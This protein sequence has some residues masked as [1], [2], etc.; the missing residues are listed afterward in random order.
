MNYMGGRPPNVGLGESETF[1]NPLLVNGKH[2][3]T[4]QGG[5]ERSE[6]LDVIVV[7]HHV[8][9]QD[10]LDHAQGFSGDTTNAFVATVMV[11]AAVNLFGDLSLG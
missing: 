4:E 8:D 5:E 6:F 10:F 9:A 1:K 3:W 11:F 7:A 2:R